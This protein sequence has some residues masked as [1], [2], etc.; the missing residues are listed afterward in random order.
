[1]KRQ[2]TYENKSRRW[3]SGRGANEGVY[4]LP[5]K[6]SRGSGLLIIMEENSQLNCYQI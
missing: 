4:T 2:F 1:M 6:Y 5:M 3:N